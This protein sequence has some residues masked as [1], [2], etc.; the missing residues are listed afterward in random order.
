VTRSESPHN[1]SFWLGDVDPRPLALFRILFGV[2]LLHDLANLSVDL[3]AFLTDEGMLPRGLQAAPR[4]WSL[5]DL[6][7]SPFAVAVLFALGVCAVAAFTVGYYTR[8]ATLLSFLFITSVHTRNLYVTDGGDDLVR[9]LLFLSLFADLGTCFSLDARLGRLK[10]AA[11]PAMGLRFLQLHVA[12]LYFCA[13]RLKF[14]AGWLTHN[15]IYQCLQ[16]EGFVRPPGAWLSSMPS[17]CFGLGVVTLGL[18]WSF[19]FL[20]FSPI[21]IQ[22]TR[23]LA[24]AA[25][26]AVQ[27]GILATMR[28]GVFTE[29]MIVVMVL[30]VQPEWLDRASSRLSGRRRVGQASYEAT[31]P[32]P[33]PWTPPIGPRVGRVPALRAIV[34]V[35]LSLNFIPLAWGPFIA[36]RFPPPAWVTAGR[37][38]LWLDQP[39]GLFDVVYDIPRWEAPGVLSDGRRVEVLALAVPALVPKVAWSFSRWYKFTF[40]ER[41]RAFRFAALGTFLCR[42]YERKTGAHLESFALVENLTPPT[43]A[44]ASPLPTRRRERWHQSC[45]RQLPSI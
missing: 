44:G 28:V 6:V 27:I 10:P 22:V 26:L 11:V 35:A 32:R 2:T 21:R 20:A 33:S 18:E 23:A 17:L 12:L 13:A 3:R 38:W 45:T 39:F 36:R 14:R 29:A 1:P 16:L 19:A 40:K 41:E 9:N 37:Q 24:I 42:E 34:L 8:L 43:I 30:F 7:G 4:V 15:V 25:G 5:F 31:P